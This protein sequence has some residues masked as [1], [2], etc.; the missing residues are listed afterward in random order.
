MM[1]TVYRQPSTVQSGGFGK[2]Q[3]EP[4]QQQYRLHE[5]PAKAVS[6]DAPMVEWKSSDFHWLDVT[7]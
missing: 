2:K 3:Q 4:R 1:I 7:V 5:N 6:V